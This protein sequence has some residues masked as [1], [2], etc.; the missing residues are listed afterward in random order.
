MTVIAMVAI[1]LFF[2][3]SAN[4]AEVAKVQSSTVVTQC[5]AD[6]AHRL[7]V[8]QLDVKLVKVQKM[9]WPNS[10]LGMPEIGKMYTQVVTPGWWLI[11]EVNN[12]RYLYTAGASTF[13]YGGPTTSWNYS[14]LYTLPIKD[15]PNMNGDLYQCSLLG[16][17]SRRV[18]SGVSDYYPQ[19]GGLI[20]FNRRTS[21]SGFDLLYVQ[22]DKPGKENKLC[23]AFEFGAAAFDKDKTHWAAYMRPMFAG[24]WSVAWGTVGQTA[25]P[26]VLELPDG[27]K[28]GRI[29]WTNDGALMILPEKENSSAAYELATSGSPSWKQV[30]AYYFPGYNKFVLSKSE[31]LEIKETKAD[32]KSGFEVNRIWFSG[33]RIPLAK[34]T[35][36]AMRGNDLIAPYAF[37]WGEKDGLQA[38]YSVNVRSGLTLLAYVGKGSDIKPFDYAPHS[39]PIPKAAAAVE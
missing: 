30:S 12:S 32:G 16:T 17:N 19:S 21:R 8:K 9:K 33:E 35:G 31:E 26:Q 23:G 15:E 28:P 7:G 14:V 27:T 20:I 25:K 4:C 39:L 22:A 10:A 3:S 36:F 5:S 18:A 24:L 34:V 1:G 37:I 13:K 29:A 38:A 2:A 11:L 6:L